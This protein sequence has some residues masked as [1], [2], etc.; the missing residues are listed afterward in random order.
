[1]KKNEQHATYPNVMRDAMCYFHLMKVE[2]VGKK[3][4]WDCKKIEGCCSMHSVAS[5]S[6]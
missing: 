5:I 3:A 4:F 1:M 6:H 2:D